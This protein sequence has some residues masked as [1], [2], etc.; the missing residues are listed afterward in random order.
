MDTIAYAIMSYDGMQSYC[1]AEASNVFV[2][3]AQRLRHIALGVRAHQLGGVHVL[4]NEALVRLKVCHVTA[5]SSNVRASD[6]IF[7]L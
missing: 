6:S 1:A 3:L 2:V 4:S 7:V 5:C